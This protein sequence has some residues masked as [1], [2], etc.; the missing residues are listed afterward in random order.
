METEL[1]R[2]IDANGNRVREGLRV[3][4]DYARFALEDEKAARD[5]KTARHKIAGAISSLPLQEADLLS[6]RE[7]E[8][9]FGQQNSYEQSSHPLRLADVFFNNLRRS[10]EACRVLEEISSLFEN[11][12]S[13]KFKKTRFDLYRIEKYIMEKIAGSSVTRNS[14]LQSSLRLIA[15]TEPLFANGRSLVE[16]MRDAVSGG[17]TMVQFRDELNSS[18]EVIRLANQLKRIVQESE[19]PF[20]I[21]DRVDVALAVG[22]DGVHLGEEDMD[23]VTARRLL[24]ENRIIGIT[25]RNPSQA[26]QAEEKGADYLA[27]GSIFPSKTKREAKVAGLSTLKS[28]VNDVRIPVVAIGGINLKNLSQVL[29][30]GV[31]GVAVIQSLLNTKDIESRA[32]KFRSK[33]ENYNPPKAERD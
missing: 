28:V 20:I 2:I 32:R 13:Q 26:K 30:T 25:V 7:S 8:K 1:I 23:P 27:V 21:N 3:C 11:G 6:F 31:K 10:Q 19:I 9:D 24:G 5:L 18:K 33:I 29:E 12:V 4:E 16:M 14:S 15:I 17:A 22:A